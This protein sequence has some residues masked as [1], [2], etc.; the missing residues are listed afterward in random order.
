MTK[1]ALQRG[2]FRSSA[3]AVLAAWVVVAARASAGQGEEISIPSRPLNVR[4]CISLALN[5]SP[6]LEA[7]RLEVASATEEARAAGEKRCRR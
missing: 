2:R 4:D 7:S 1:C 3:L 5:E 6:A